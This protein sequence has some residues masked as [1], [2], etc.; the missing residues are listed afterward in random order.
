MS[1][2]FILPEVITIQKE[3]SL[4]KFFPGSTGM[5]YYSDNTTLKY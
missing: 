3:R 1:N 4:N 2:I 5:Q